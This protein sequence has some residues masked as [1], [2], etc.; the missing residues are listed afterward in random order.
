MEKRWIDISQP[1]YTG[2]GIW[3]DHLDMSHTVTESIEDG[4]SC[5]LSYLQ[6]GVHTGTHVDAPFHFIKE[7]RR[8]GDMDPGLLIGP[9]LVLDCEA[10]NGNITAK[11]LEGRIPAGTKRLLVRTVNAAFGYP[12]YFREDFVGLLTDAA[13]YAYACGVRLLGIDALSLAPVGEWTEPVHKAFLSHN[14]VM[15][16][17]GID[18]ASV[19]EGWY[20]LVCTALRLDDAGGAP[21]RAL[22]CAREEKA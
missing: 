18:L 10:A 11:D 15:I 8:M 6:M 20:D 19:G 9:A 1:I 21:A 22:L 12:P 7:G 5:N 16:L 17:E 4:G 13:E 14:D 3:P 2:M